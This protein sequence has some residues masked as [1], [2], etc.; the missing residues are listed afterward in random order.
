MSVPYVSFLACHKKCTWT[1]AIYVAQRI[2][3][4][5]LRWAVQEV[6]CHTIAYQIQTAAHVIACCTDHRTNSAMI[7]SAII[8]SATISSTTVWVEAIDCPLPNKCFPYIHPKIFFTPPKFTFRGHIFRV[9]VFFMFIIQKVQN[10]SVEMLNIFS[11]GNSWCKCCVTLDM[12]TE[13][14]CIIIETLASI[15]G[16][17]ANAVWTVATIF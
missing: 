6:T 11:T 15:V 10:I 13:Q 9:A 14:C 7:S 16:T 8:C 3:F 1:I 5:L 12:A 17:V 4:C 2:S